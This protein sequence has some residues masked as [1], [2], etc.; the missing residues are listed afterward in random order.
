MDSARK[1]IHRLIDAT[2][3]ENVLEYIYMLLQ[4]SQR[5]E[6]SLWKTLTADQ[7][8][9]VLAASAEIETEAHGLVSH[10]EMKKLYLK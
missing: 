6:G 2:L 7:K 5:K 4:N 1:N 3:D 9:Q 8:E 10:E